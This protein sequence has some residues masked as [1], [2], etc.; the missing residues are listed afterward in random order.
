MMLRSVHFYYSIRKREKKGLNLS[1]NFI[2]VTK[3]ERAKLN[4]KEKFQRS[5]SY[6]KNSDFFTSLFKSKPLLNRKYLLL[7]ILFFL[8]LILGI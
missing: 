5:A 7:I 1:C 3:I 2:L 4:I 6:S 8:L